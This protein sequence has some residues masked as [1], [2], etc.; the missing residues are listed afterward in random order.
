METDREDLAAK[1]DGMQ[2]TINRKVSMDEGGLM[3]LEVHIC[4]NDCVCAS[5]VCMVVCLIANVACEWA[6]ISRKR[7]L[8]VCN[9][10]TSGVCTCAFSNCH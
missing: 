7:P 2:T 4:V 1:I 5:N 6:P 3:K 8:R 10:P 9:I